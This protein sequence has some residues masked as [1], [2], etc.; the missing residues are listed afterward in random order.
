MAAKLIHRQ[1]GFSLVEIAL[2]L[3][4]IGLLSAVCSNARDAS[5]PPMCTAQ[6]PRG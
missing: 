6:S 2:V 5:P 3:A 1:R 4:I